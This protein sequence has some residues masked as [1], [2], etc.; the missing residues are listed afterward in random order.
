MNS[1]SNHIGPAHLQS[2]CTLETVVEV[3]TTKIQVIWLVIPLWYMDGCLS[4]DDQEIVG[5]FR[6]SRD[7]PAGSVCRHT[8]HDSERRVV[9]R[10]G[11]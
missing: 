2:I 9:D 5:G 6:C 3:S 1:A 4:R 10:T 7:A 11:A 8:V